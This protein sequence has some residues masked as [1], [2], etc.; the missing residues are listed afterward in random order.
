MFF[1]GLRRRPDPWL[2]PNPNLAYEL[3]R[4]LAGSVGPDRSAADYR[5]AARSMTDPSFLAAVGYRPA[6]PTLKELE[7]VA[8]DALTRRAR[9][10]A[11][12]VAA[13]RP[14]SPAPARSMT[15]GAFD[16]HRVAREQGVGVKD[17]SVRISNLDPSME[18]VIGAV[19]QAAQN[20]GLPQPVITAGT[21]GLHRRDSLHYRRRALDFRGNNI[22]VAQGRRLEAEVSRILGTD[23]DVGFELFRNEPGRNH[24]HIEYDPDR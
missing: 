5:A 3:E 22:S 2:T 10:T 4:E 19:A 18:P 13:A 17:R 9:Q 15:P 21:D 14:A 24:L 23:Y 6:P 1:N 20:L 11:P 16:G 8:R 12:P 7:L